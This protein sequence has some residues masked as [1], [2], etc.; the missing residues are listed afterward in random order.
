MTDINT[1]PAAPLDQPA[2]DVFALQQQITALKN[3]LERARQTAIVRGDQHES[4]IAK[5]G[6]ALMSE[7]EQ[8][9]WCDQFDDFVER[10]NTYLHIGLPTR[11]RDYT[12]EIRISVS[13]SAVPSQAQDAANDIA[14]A[15]YSYG[16][17]LG[18]E[19]Y[20]VS[21]SDVWDVN[22]HD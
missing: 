21:Q 22:A 15:L 14:Y 13:Y 8:R 19:D 6:E 4:D 17:S 12:A 1:M 2:V 18:S 20:E 9:E 10:L 7:A 16:D 3:D 11:H 5:I